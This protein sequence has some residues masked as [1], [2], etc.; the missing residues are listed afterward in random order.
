MASNKVHDVFLL[1]ESQ[2]CVAGW[3]VLIRT[4]AGRRICWRN[5]RMQPPTRSHHLPLS[6]SWSVKTTTLFFCLFCLSLADILIM[7]IMFK[8]GGTT[9]HVWIHMK[10]CF[11]LK[12]VQLC[13]NLIFP[14]TDGYFKCM[15]IFATWGAAP[16]SI[17]FLFMY[18]VFCSLYFGGRET[19][20]WVTLRRLFNIYIR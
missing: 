9:A 4:G 12:Y 7:L 10:R 5:F 14:I 16:F 18:L 15:F 20:H 1:T 13:P 19:R 3:C 6:M 2:Q 8:S 17:N 11:I